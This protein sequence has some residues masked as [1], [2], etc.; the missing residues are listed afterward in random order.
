MLRRLAIFAGLLTAAGTTGVLLSTPAYAADHIICVGAP[1]GVTCSE[2]AAS[3]PAAITTANANG[4]NGTP[5]IIWLAAGI[6]SDGPYALD[7]SG[8]PVTLRGSGQDS[9]KIAH[10]SDASASTYLN[11][12]HA[13]VE[14]LTIQ[15]NATLSSGDTGLFAKDSTVTSVTVTGTG[16]QDAWGMQ[17]PGSTVSGVTVQMAHTLADG[18]HAMYSDGSSTVTDS[19]LVGT[20]GYVLA[21]VGLPDPVPT[22]TLSRVSITAD[23]RGIATDEGDVVVDDTLIDLGTGSEAV[24][25][26]AVNENAGE[27]PKS[28]TANH[29]TIVGG[30]ATSVGAKAWATNGSVP[31]TS[32]ITLT[33]SIISGPATSL[34]ARADNDLGVLASSAT[35]TTSYSDW[36]TQHVDAGTHGSTAIISSGAGRLNVNPGFVNAAGGDYRLAASSPLIDKGAPGSGAPTL[37]L[38]G[39]TRVLDGNGD[40]AAVRDM[41]AYEAPKKVVVVVPD[42]TAPNTT[43][44]SH[45]KKRTAK[46]R[47][48]F[49]FSSNESHVTFQCRLDKKA[50]SSCTSP[51]AYRVT[52]GWHVFK[53]RARDAAGN[54]DATPAT[55]RFKRT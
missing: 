26:E 36:S 48:S 49:G 17:V 21:W 40:G 34:D 35:I 14:D 52:R 24:G 39:G 55:W 2:T 18:N 7:D 46:R 28:I 54:L 27:T 1:A 42:T 43:I 4:A 51:K 25:L 9:T 3:L 19:T 44:T 30:G 41:G 16:T 22:G 12:Q 15:M 6:Y 23:Y 47:V 10:V 32:S 50:W 37:D 29:V 20:Y 13:T 33:N 45:P 31:Q 53:V 5:D 38:A 8:G 11:V